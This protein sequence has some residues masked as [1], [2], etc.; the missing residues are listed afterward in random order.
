MG[1]FTDTYF[2]ISPALTALSTKSSST[3]TGTYDLAA[4]NYGVRFPY[5]TTPASTFYQSKYNQCPVT[6]PYTDVRRVFYPCSL[7]NL[8]PAF[9]PYST[10]TT[11]TGLFA[12]SFPEDG[13][14]IFSLGSRAAKDIVNIRLDFPDLVAG[15]DPLTF[16]LSLLD[17]A[18]TPLSIQPAPMG[19]T[20]T[21]SAT[22]KFYE[23][24]WTVPTAGTYYVEVTTATDPTDGG[25]L[26]WYYF[27][28]W[29]PKTAVSIRKAI[30]MLRG[31]THVYRSVFMGSSDLY[32]GLSHS[33]GLDKTALFSMKSGSQFKI[34]VLMTKD[35]EFD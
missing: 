21:V 15:M 25:A 33:G 12:N 28:A 26:Q 13:Y 18:G 30:D 5:S 1:D 11:E 14:P 8:V 6:S 29:L 31:K 27:T 7:I 10:P 2:L 20:I 24:F 19:T 34:D 35:I 16:Q 9:R 22:D 4:G 17:D 32:Q 23:T 3:Y